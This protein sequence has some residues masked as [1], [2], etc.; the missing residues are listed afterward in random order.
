MEIFLAILV[1]AFLLFIRSEITTRFNY[2]EDKLNNMTKLLNELRKQQLPEENLF[3]KS[4]YKPAQ[5]VPE[6]KPVAPIPK[7]TVEFPP[8]PD[9]T[10]QPVAEKETP[11]VITPIDFGSRQPVYEKTVFSAP[12]PTPE[13]PSYANYKNEK[14]WWDTFKEKNPDLEKFIGENL[15]NKI[16]VLILVLGISY[17]VK[18]AIDKDWINEP[19]RVGIGI[20]SG[21]LVMGFA[22]KLRKNYAAF[23]SVLVAG[24]IAIF[25]F[26]IAIAFHD[27]HL[28]G[29][30]AAFVI[31]VGIT[32]FSAIISLSYDRMELAILSLI[33]GFA[34]PFMVSTGTGNYVV[35]LTYIAI[36]DV[37]ILALAFHKKWSAVNVVA[38]VF[39]VA[40]Y[41]VWLYQDNALPHPHF[42]GALVFGF[43]F[44]L[45]FIL[46]NIVNNIRTKGVFSAIELS[47]LASNTFLFYAAGMTILHTYHPEFRD[48]LQLVSVC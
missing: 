44:Y 45:I 23:S 16:G 10:P 3:K 48:Y 19:A 5:I 39:T 21:A 14:S 40:L 17:L 2:L 42:G 27:Y 43:A 38:Y 22:H 31:M 46:T 24:A 12:S 32:A 41:G 1:F 26:T 20:L 25:Y 36:L 33:G 29:Q 18:Y 6:E 34:V 9:V 35:L 47:I 13:Q 37:G 8:I 15:I 11:K 28:F 7:P 4:D 30:T